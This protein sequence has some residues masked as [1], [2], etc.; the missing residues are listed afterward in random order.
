MEREVS[1]LKFQLDSSEDCISR[2]MT[3]D[4]ELFEIFRDI[5]GVFFKHFLNSS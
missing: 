5:E 4:V 3:E 1:D 2:F